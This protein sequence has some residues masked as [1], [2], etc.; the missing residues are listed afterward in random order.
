MNKPVIRSSE[1]I[2]IYG[3]ITHAMGKYILCRGA[4]RKRLVPKKARIL[5]TVKPA[6]NGFMAWSIKPEEWPDAKA[7]AELFAP[8]VSEIKALNEPEPTAIAPSSKKVEKF[9]ASK[10]LTSGF[11]AS[12]RR[13]GM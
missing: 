2:A 1:E 13:K 7:M 3:M 6:P 9:G 10:S 8:M 4:C 12:V 11:R 5:L